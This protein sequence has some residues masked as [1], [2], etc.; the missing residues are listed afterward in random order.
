MTVQNFKER[1][2]NCVE[3]GRGDKTKQNSLVSEEKGADE[4]GCL[5]TESDAR[6]L[7]DSVL[8]WQGRVQPGEG[9][10]SKFGCSSFVW[11]G[12]KRRGLFR[13]R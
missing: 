10:R 9:R 8:F 12:A 13:S 5:T 4:R 11:A 2:T 1:A 7:L 3:M 6:D